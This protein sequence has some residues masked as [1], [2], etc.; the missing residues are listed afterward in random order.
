MTNT[1][2]LK[3]SGER[4]EFESGA[5][6]DTQADKPRPSLLSPFALERVAWVYSRGAEKYGDN[7][8]QKGIPFSR[9]LDSAERHIM[10]FKQGMRDEDH[11][12]QATWNL[13]AILHHQEIGPAG[14]D[15]LPVYPAERITPE[16][17]KKADVD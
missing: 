2:E 8:W 4:Q 17:L 10:E 6:R 16:E 5:R 1:F 13:L 14:L 3:D 12:A 15:D 11:L 9:Y 7:N